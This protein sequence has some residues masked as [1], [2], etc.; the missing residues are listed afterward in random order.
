MRSGPAYATL[1]RYR[2]DIGGE[3]QVMEQLAQLI[4]GFER[5]QVL[6]VGPVDRD[7]RN[8]AGYLPIE[9]FGIVLCKLKAFH[10]SFLS[11]LNRPWSGRR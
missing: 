9:M 11:W 3:C 7:C 5:E 10:H 2:I 1:D 8:L 6:A 4:V